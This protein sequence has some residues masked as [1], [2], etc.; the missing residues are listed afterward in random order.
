MAARAVMVTTLLLSAVYVESISETLPRTNP[1]Y[2]LIAATYA[3]TLLHVLA[4]RFLPLGEWQVQAQ[5][6]GDLG[7]ITGIVYVTGGGAT[8]GGFILLYPVAVLSGGA[9]LSRR[10]GLVLAGLATVFY[11]ALL[12]LV[13]AGWVP[14]RGL[15]ELRDLPL[16]RLLNSVFVVGVTCATAGLIG[17]YLSER[18]RFVGRQLEDAAEQMADLRELNTQ[19]VDSIQ[20][21]LL[22][23]DAGGRVVYVNDYGLAVLGRGRVELRGR[24]LRE[25]FGTPLL[26]RPAV[27]VRGARRDLVRFEFD[28]AHPDGGPRRLGLSLSALRTRQGGAHDGFLLVFQDL[29]AVKRLEEEVR[30][31]EKLA[32]MGQMAASLAHEIRNPL[33]SISGSAEVL[34]TGPDVSDDQQ[35]LLEIIKRESRRLS[36]TL[37][38]FLVQARPAPPR[39][40]V[41]VAPLVAEAVALLRNGAEVRP[42]HRIEYE[43]GPG[44]HLCR[45]DPDQIV[46]IFW[47]LARNGLEAMPQGG[48]LGV[49]LRSADGELVLSVRD[50]GGGIG[51]DEQARLFEPFRSTSPK[52]T[53]L[54]LAIVYRIVRQ[55][56]GDIDVRSEPGRGTEVEVRLPLAALPAEDPRAAARG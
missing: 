24:A 11:G 32:A 30:L 35:R 8:P 17:G 7:V 2:T 39:A 27:D 53:G 38:Q 44:P 34:L 16:L 21:G 22:T 14:P 5:L 19:I 45:A 50:Q 9:L 56:R 6:V 52:G 54:G 13:C 31:K 46:Q 12:A 4:L 41:D 25:A 18:L 55:H 28:Y 10:H 37:Q 48:V 49:R 33:S 42:G 47:N 23:A 40:P 1:L 26:E 36:N 3:L 43:A 20:S 15:S 51:R 29:T